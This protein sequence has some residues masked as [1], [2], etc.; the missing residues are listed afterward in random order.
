MTLRGLVLGILVW[1]ALWVAAALL[2]YL[3]YLV[4]STY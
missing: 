4:A 1:L 2:L 3:A